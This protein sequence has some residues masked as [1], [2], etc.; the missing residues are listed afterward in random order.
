[1]IGKVKKMINE[2]DI[3]WITKNRK[4][5]WFTIDGDNVVDRESKRN[6]GKIDEFVMTLRTLT[7]CDFEILYICDETQEVVYRCKQCDT[8]IFS[9]EDE[10]YD[11]NLCCPCCG[12]YKTGF[13]FWTAQ[14]IK[15]DRNKKYIIN[16]YTNSYRNKLF[17]CKFKDRDYN[18]NLKKWIKNIVVK[19][20][21]NLLYIK[22]K[23]KQ[24]K[25]LDKQN[26]V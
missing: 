10:T 24:A 14:E 5:C 16:C 9:C 8:V 23:N 12:G 15:E 1:M 20:K 11:P 13:K 19:I 18:H 2:N 26:N 17:V 6:V 7:H 3:R 25:P 22:F 21:I 4:N